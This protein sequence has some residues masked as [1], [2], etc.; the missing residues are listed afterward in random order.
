MALTPEMI[1]QVRASFGNMSV[2]E[3]AAAQAEAKQNYEAKKA[4]STA[5]KDYHDFI[6]QV[7]L[8]EKMEEEDLEGIKV[9]GVGRVNLRGEMYCSVKKGMAPDL[10]KW[11]VEHGFEDMI[12]PSI[13][14]STLKAFV[15]EQMGK[16]DGEYPEEV[17]NI[18]PYTMAVITK[19]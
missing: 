1:E 5:A 6:Q 8:P 3:I 16:R 9:P 12:K 17:L 13:N 4:E 18:T 7:I 14:S 19:T 2:A 10:E 11:L 15:K